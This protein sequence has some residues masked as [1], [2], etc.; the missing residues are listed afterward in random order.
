MSMGKNKEARIR[1]AIKAHAESGDRYIQEYLK[2]SGR[3]K[4]RPRKRPIR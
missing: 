2:A 4:G 1:A 3:T